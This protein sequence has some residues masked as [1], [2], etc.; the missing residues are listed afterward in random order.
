MAKGVPALGLNG[1][2][3]GGYHWS[4]EALRV[5]TICIKSN[6]FCTKDDEFCIKNDGFCI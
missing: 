5:V 4:R 6:E 3:F 2:G 1:T